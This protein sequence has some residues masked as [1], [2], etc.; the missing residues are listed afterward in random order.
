MN[1]K[2]IAEIKAEDTLTIAGDAAEMAEMFRR[3]KRDRLEIKGRFNLEPTGNAPGLNIRKANLKDADAVERTF[4]PLT[5]PVREP[6]DKVFFDGER[7]AIVATD[8][9]MMLFCN[10]PEGFKPNER[11][12]TEG[13]CNWTLPL[14]NVQRETT[15]YALA[16]LDKVAEFEKG[17]AVHNALA[18]A[19]ACSKA[20]RHNDE[21]GFW[22]NLYLWVGDALFNPE[23]LNTVVTALFRLGSDRIGLY[24]SKGGLMHVV[25]FGNGLDARGLVC[26]M[27]FPS[28]EHGAVVLPIGK[29]SAKT[30]A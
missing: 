11:F 25:G 1:H 10:V 4:R 16:D 17:G 24:A 7:N 28:N 12:V 21:K 14:G 22:N 30:A 29:E 23:A 15:P 13:Y 3:C 8:G 26:P 19:A 2:T 27:R 9:V 18:I 20:Y 6:L 5:S